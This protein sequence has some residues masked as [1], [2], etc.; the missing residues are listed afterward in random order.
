[1]L[2]CTQLVNPKINNKINNQTQSQL[3][4]FIPD[5]TV[6]TYPYTLPIETSQSVQCSWSNQYGIILGLI[7]RIRCYYSL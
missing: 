3:N 2:P 6:H 4:H 1:M 7:I 5:Y